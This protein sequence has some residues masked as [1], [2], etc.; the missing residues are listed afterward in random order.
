M[1]QYDWHEGGVDFNVILLRRRRAEPSGEWV[2]H[3]WSTPLAAYRPEEVAG[4][5]EEG[6][7]RVSVHGS[8]GLEPFAAEAS[9]DVVIRAER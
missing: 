1:R 9:A 6:G 5:L 8:L 3:T 4:L 2:L 7:A